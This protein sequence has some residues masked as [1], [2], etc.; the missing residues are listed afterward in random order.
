MEPPHKKSAQNLADHV[1]EK[2]ID[3]LHG[4]DMSRLQ[5]FIDYF[6]DNS[7]KYPRQLCATCLVPIDDERGMCAN[8]SCKRL[9]CRRPYCTPPTY[10]THECVSGAGCYP[11]VCSETCAQAC[12]CGYRD[13]TEII[14]EH[15]QKECT[16]C[17]EFVC[18]N[19]VKYSDNF[20]PLSNEECCRT[21]YVCHT[22]FENLRQR[23]EDSEY[24]DYSADVDYDNEDE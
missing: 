20:A 11:Y 3:F 21:P 4:N 17:M 9:W 7:N 22:C 5:A 13:C 24:N 6:Q 14:C 16:L 15:C 2:V 23:D 1:A 12:K 19:H 18:L 10:R 8:T